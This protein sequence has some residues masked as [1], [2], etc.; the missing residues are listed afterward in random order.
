[1]RLATEESWKYKKKAEM[2]EIC[3][4]INGQ[5]MGTLIG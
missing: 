1:M 5:G 4:I 2:A 3:L